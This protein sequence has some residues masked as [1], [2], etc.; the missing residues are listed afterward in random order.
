MDEGFDQSE[1]ELALQLSK[2]EEEERLNKKVKV[3]EFQIKSKNGSDTTTLELIQRVDTGKFDT[4][5]YGQR[6]LQ[7]FKNLWSNK[8][9]SDIVLHIGKT[10]INAHKLV[11]CAWS[12]KMESLLQ[13]ND[14]ELTLNVTSS[15]EEKLLCKI[16][17]FF[18]TGEFIIRSD[19]LIKMIELANFY[20]ISSIK[21]QCGEI[22]AS[23]LNQETVFLLLQI[24]DKYKLNKLNKSCGEYLAK[25]FETL[26]KEDKL[27]SLSPQT[28]KNMLNSDDIEVARE[29]DIFRAI[30]KYSENFSNDEKKRV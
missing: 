21:E 5:E 6:C 4:T 18:Y 15:E 16:I 9:F 27:N 10:D 12:T 28:L 8:K 13:G 30:M 19:D 24:S 7:G 23:Q 22:L 26:I 2:Q 1:L 3:E 14:A 29:E 11:L 17:M 20:E 25:N